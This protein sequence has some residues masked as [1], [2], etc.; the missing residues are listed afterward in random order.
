MTGD[1]NPA[2][3][4]DADMAAWPAYTGDGENVLRLDTVTGPVHHPEW[5]LCAVLGVAEQ[6]SP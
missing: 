4:E 1:P 3:I 6:R 5:P 2:R